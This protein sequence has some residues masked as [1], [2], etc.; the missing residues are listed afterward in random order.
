MDGISLTELNWNLLRT[1]HVIAEE[2]SLTRAAQRLGVSQPSVTNALRKLE[3]Q[4]GCQLVFRDSR[5]F[6]LTLRG[7]KIHRECTEMF[8]SADRIAGL[9]RHGV[10]EER[11]EVRFQIITNLRSPLFDEALRLFHQRHPSV[12][13]RIEVQSSQ[14]IIR[15][16][17]DERVGLGVCLLSKPVMNLT[18]RKL[19]REEF[20]IFCGKEHPLFGREDVALRDLQQEPFITFACA[21]DAGGLEPMA[22]LRQSA[23]LGQRISGASP[24]M[25]EIRRMIMS[26]LGIGILPLV[27]VMD[28]I[29]HGNLWPLKISDQQLGADVF[30][31][32]NPRLQLSSAEEKFVHL[33]EELLNLYPDMG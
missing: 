3:E 10:D 28:E 20:G 32:T 18:C 5:H 1:F 2:Q 11:G 14:T 24:N 6:E 27:S 33:I 22:V 29:E 16:L 12:S 4:L 7:T 15:N 25:E 19:F 23:N 9:S 17:Q 26:G 13:F 21:T 31:V 8:R 30:L